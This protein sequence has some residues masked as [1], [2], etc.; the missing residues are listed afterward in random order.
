MLKGYTRPEQQLTEAETAKLNS[1]RG[2]DLGPGGGKS[3]TLYVAIKDLTKVVEAVSSQGARKGLARG[4]HKRATLLSFVVIVRAT[5]LH[6]TV[7]CMA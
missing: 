6:R 5:P 2:V 1:G 4:S 7:P 3:L